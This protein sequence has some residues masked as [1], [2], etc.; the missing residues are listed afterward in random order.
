M[1]VESPY[2]LKPRF[3]LGDLVTRSLQF[4]EPVFCMSEEKSSDFSNSVYTAS[5]LTKAIVESIPTNEYAKCDLCV[6]NNKINLKLR[7][8]SDNMK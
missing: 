6:K 4:N 8:I 1:D 2:Q 7:H 3:I 5:G